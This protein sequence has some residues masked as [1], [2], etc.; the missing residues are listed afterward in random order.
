MTEIHDDRI[1]ALFTDDGG[2][3]LDPAAFAELNK[4]ETFA[5]I[6]EVLDVEYY[7]ETLEN[8]NRIP[9]EYLRQVLI[10]VSG[11]QSLEDGGV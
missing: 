7:R 5:A 1:E 2:V 10:E 9:H 8:R 11:Q 3:D 6:C 4:M